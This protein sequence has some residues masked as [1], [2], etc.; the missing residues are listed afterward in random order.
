MSSL[1]L[2]PRL[3][4]NQKGHTLN[5]AHKALLFCIWASHRI[6]QLGDIKLQEKIAAVT[7][8]PIT[9]M[10]SKPMIE[11]KFLGTP[12]TMLSSIGINVEEANMVTVKYS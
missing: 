7:S 3:H 8:L 5:T 6:V 9:S 4:L 11:H 12:R 1:P 2:A 10:S